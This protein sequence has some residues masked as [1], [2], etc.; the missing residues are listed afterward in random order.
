MNPRCNPDLSGHH[1]MESQTPKLYCTTMLD[2]LTDVTDKCFTEVF[3]A[4][5]SP[6]SSVENATGFLPGPLLQSHGLMKAIQEVLQ[7]ACGF[8]SNKVKHTPYAAPVTSS[9]KSQ[10][11]GVSLAPAGAKLVDGVTMWLNYPLLDQRPTCCE[12]TEQ[13]VQPFLICTQK[14]TL[15]SVLWLFSEDK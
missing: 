4:Y 3:R 2:S 5:K 12:N 7:M 8:F 11:H 15:H 1:Y 14:T 10:R 13:G 6:D 9:Q